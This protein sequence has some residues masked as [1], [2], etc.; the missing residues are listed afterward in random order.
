MQLTCK[1]LA[2]QLGMHPTNFHKLG[3]GASDIF[4]KEELI[5]FL[6]ARVTPK[7]AWRPEKAAAAAA[8]L[9]RIRNGQYPDPKPKPMLPPDPV[10]DVAKPVHI[11]APKQV[12]SRRLMWLYLPAFA[13][14]IASIDNMHLIFWHITGESW[15]FAKVFTVVFSGSA[16]C[17]IASGITSTP[18][19]VITWILVI[20]EA[21]CNMTGIYYGLLGRTGT[22]TRFLGMVT[23]IFESGTHGTAIVL[24]AI[25]AATLAGVQILSFKAIVKYGI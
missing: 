2:E 14:A 16:F 4:N 22:P 8:L 1:E 17:F 12:K 18:I 13:A 21:F 11:T 5:Q 9:E 19:Q 6:S 3:K 24:G 7:G 25:T 15:L 20:W 10:P 23:D